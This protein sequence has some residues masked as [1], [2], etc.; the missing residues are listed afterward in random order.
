VVGD[1]VSLDVDTVGSSGALG[2][3][4]HVTGI[5]GTGPYQVFFNTNL[6]PANAQAVGAKVKPHLAAD[7]AGLHP[8]TT[9]NI[10]TMKAIT[11]WKNTI[12]P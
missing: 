1:F 4:A 8:G 9:S 12:Y 5:T 3:G 7:S 10:R 6:T 11:D 2:N